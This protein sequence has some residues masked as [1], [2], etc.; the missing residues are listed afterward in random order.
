MSVKI[1]DKTNVN[2]PINK[3]GFWAYK[4]KS[5]VPNGLNFRDFL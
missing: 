1:I 5:F 3:E 4:L 2:E